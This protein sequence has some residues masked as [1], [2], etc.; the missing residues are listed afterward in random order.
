LIGF[1]DRL[2]KLSQRTQ[3][4]NMHTNMLPFHGFHR[5][6]TLSVCIEVKAVYLC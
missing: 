1:I 5:T 6:I 2:H 4:V 3:T